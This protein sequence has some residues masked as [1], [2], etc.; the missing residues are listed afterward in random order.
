MMN[1]F[2]LSDTLFIGKQIYKFLSLPLFKRYVTSFPLYPIIL[3]L[4]LCR[5]LQH[6]G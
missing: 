3:C 6:G 1:E 2:I 4:V 5:L